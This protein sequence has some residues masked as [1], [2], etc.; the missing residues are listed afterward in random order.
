MS[1]SSKSVEK[2]NFVVQPVQ[3]AKKQ[4]SKQDEQDL[5]DRNDVENGS[6]TQETKD[7][8]IQTT[9]PLCIIGTPSIV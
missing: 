6:Q 7:E 9:I 1:Y 5:T 8:T 3:D 2:C 4:M